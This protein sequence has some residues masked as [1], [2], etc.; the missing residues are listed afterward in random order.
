MKVAVLIAWRYLITRKKA[1][2]INLITAFSFLGVLIGT[3]SIVVVLSVYNGLEDLAT[4]MFSRFDPEL[5]IKPSQGKRIDLNNKLIKTLPNLEG[6]RIAAPTIVENGLIKYGENQHIAV[7]KG[8]PDV[9]LK[10]AGLENNMHQ[11]APELINA[12]GYEGILT[13]I[14]VAATL[15]LQ[16]GQSGNMVAVYLPKRTGE[17]ALTPERAFNRAF[18][19]PTGIF[20]LKS[21]VNNQLA[22]I[23]FDQMAHLIEYEHHATAL[24]VYALPNYSI[25][26]LKKQLSVFLGDDFLVLDRFE[27]HADVFKIFQSEKWW[28][29]LLLMLIVLVAA[30]NLIGSVTMMVVEK[31]PENLLLSTLGMTNSHIGL[32]FK[33]SGLFVT[34]VGLVIGLVLGVLFVLGQQYF[35]W[36]TYEGVGQFAVEAYPVALRSFD[37]FATALGVLLLGWVCSYFPSTLAVK[38][39][40]IQLLRTSN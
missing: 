11:G 34:V 30:L 1:Q 38:N 7:V 27:Q 14:G 17:I 10:E 18:V 21:D 19:L 25:K 39:I 22:L 33:L 35:G 16:A 20:D 9:L 6:I 29:F 24:H 3:A 23:S 37:L 40:D 26:K 31:Q 32:I 8:Y 36:I 28:T 13:G 2:F 4:S 5:Q 12:D 15:G